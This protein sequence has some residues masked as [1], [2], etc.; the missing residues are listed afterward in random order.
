M[1]RLSATRT[2]T[3]AVIISFMVGIFFI[4]K[5][6]PAGFVPGEDQGMIYAIIQTPPGSTIEKTNDVAQKLQE[7]ALKIEGVDSVASLA[8]YEILTEGEGSNAGTCLISLKDWS[9]RK[10]SVHK[11]IE[12][13]EEKTKIWRSSNSL[14]HPPYRVSAPRGACCFAF[15]IKPTAAT[16]PHSTRYT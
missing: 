11:V 4:S 7:E 5:M 3:V 14:N 9:A 6:V 10:N 12:E 8:G 16:I 13:L 2:F 15:W 1:R